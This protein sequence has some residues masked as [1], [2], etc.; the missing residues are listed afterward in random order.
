M[1]I[2]TVE[3]PPDRDGSLRPFHRLAGAV[4]IQA[5][6][7]LFKGTARDRRESLEWLQNGKAGTLSFE[8][9]CMLLDRDPEDIRTKLIRRYSSP[10]MNNSVWYDTH[11]THQSKSMQ[12]A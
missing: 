12:A 10:L 7:D 6:E 3:A 2:P 11:R 5:I 4:L 8:M 9:C 1:T